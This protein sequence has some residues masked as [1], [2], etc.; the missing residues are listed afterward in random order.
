MSELRIES[1]SMPAV[2]LGP[3]NPLPPLEIRQTPPG[4]NYPPDIPADMLE[5]LAYGHLSSLLPYP[6]QDG[7]DRQLEQTEFKVAVLENELL[8]ATI[9]LEIGGRLWS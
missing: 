2:K 1:W 5:N 9:L 3:D 7:F 6:D 8:R 4:F